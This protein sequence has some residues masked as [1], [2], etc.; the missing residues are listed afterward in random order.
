MKNVFTFC[1]ALCL[2]ALTACGSAP[3]SVKKHLIWRSTT[4]RASP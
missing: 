4:M 2:L 1:C 3:R